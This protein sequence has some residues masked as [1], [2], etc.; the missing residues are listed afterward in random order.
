[1]AA[2]ETEVTPEEESKALVREEFEQLLAQS[3]F[4][5][6]SLR[7]LDA[8]DFYVMFVRMTG[9]A[10]RVFVLKLVCED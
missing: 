1:M 2:T 10:G 5:G 4:Y 8:G 9:R 3:D 7:L 6:W